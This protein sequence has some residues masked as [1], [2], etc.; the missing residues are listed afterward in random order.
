MARPEFSASAIRY[1]SRAMA[2][3]DEQV[4][5][6]PIIVSAAEIRMH[7]TVFDRVRLGLGC[8][9]FHTTEHQS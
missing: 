9:L 2:S 6:L 1:L 5:G 4:G 3:S 8:G 7:N